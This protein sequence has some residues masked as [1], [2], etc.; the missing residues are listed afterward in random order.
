MWEE[1]GG[2]SS[3][4]GGGGSGGAMGVVQ[5]G[6]GGEKAREMYLMQFPGDEEDEG[7]MAEDEEGS[8]SVEGEEISNIKEEVRETCFL[9]GSGVGG[10]IHSESQ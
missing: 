6:R 7:G 10:E 4:V 9:R 8:L 1:E 2:G 3:G 5:G